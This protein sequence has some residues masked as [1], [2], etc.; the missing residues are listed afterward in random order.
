ML[1]TKGKG[2]YKRPGGA[3]YPYTGL[4][5]SEDTGAELGEIDNDPFK[6]VYY[7]VGTMILGYMHK[8]AHNIWGLAPVFDTE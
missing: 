7:Q 3:A 5:T 6:Y 8:M 2:V 4:Y 1:F